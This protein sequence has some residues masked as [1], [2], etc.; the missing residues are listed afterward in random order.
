MNPKEVLDRIFASSSS[1]FLVTG[2]PGTGKTT[3]G[4]SLAAGAVEHGLLGITGYKCV[5]FLTFARNAVARI[6]EALGKHPKSPSAKSFAD[7]RIHVSTF[8]GFFWWLV[9]RYNRYTPEGSLQRP[10]LIGTSR[11]PGIETPPPE[12]HRG[13]TFDE[14]VEAALETL[15]ITA[16][17]RLVSR[18]YPLVIVD[19]Y[20][21]VD[22][23]ICSALGL[24]ARDSRMVMLAGPG[25]AIY[26]RG[27]GGATSTYDFAKDTLG[28][29]E[30]DLEPESPGLQRFNA[31]MTNAISSFEN[32]QMIYVPKD[33]ISFKGV[34]NSDNAKPEYRVYWSLRE[35]WK[36]MKQ[37]RRPRPSLAILAHT[38]HA[39]ASIYRHVWI[40]S[41]KQG[42]RGERFI[43]LSLRDDLLLL[44]GRLMLALLGG[45]WTFK[46]AY[47]DSRRHVAA[48]LAMLSAHAVRQGEV[49]EDTD[50]A[51]LEPLAASLWKCASTKNPPAG[52]PIELKALNDLREFNVLL[53]TGVESNGRRSRTSFSK[54]DRPLLNLIA[55]EFLGSVLPYIRAAAPLEDVRRAFES[56][57]LQRVVFEK[58]GIH[59]SIQAMT[60]HKSKGREFDGVILVL[61]SSPMAAW[62]QSCG[63]PLDEVEDLYRVGITRARRALTV[64]AYSDG[65]EAAAA[66]VKRLFPQK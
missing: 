14:L 27:S 42:K 26:P 35:M 40:Q 4:C 46:N 20:Q 36:L 62:R 47:V 16:I 15:Q 19:E 7:D 41:E 13:F 44:Y 58:E 48:H 38:N 65:K 45:H 11:L 1:S 10:W 28:A 25:Q 52:K 57:M 64:V 33:G 18:V 63:Y 49:L 5:L 8:H 50:P 29:E 9:D 30:L 59:K 22:E 43:G 56:V 54:S 31:S 39:V 55:H 66:P 61:E 32:G 2:A 3:L 17:R 21:D 12:G 34:Q 60:I 23:R 6:R 51:Y 24:L 37:S 53:T